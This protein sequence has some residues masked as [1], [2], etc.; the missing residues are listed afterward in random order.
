MEKIEAE[1]EAEKNIKTLT[2]NESRLQTSTMTRM[3]DTFLKK[4]QPRCHS[5]RAF[6]FWEPGSQSWR[7]LSCNKVNKEIDK[8][9]INI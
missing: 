9:I 2:L 5:G 7:F 3:A 6:N 1:Q 8:E 4:K